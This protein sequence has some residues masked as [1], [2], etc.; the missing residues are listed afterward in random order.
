[1]LA[2]CSRC[3]ASRYCRQSSSPPATCPLP[4]PRTAS[5]RP[6]DSALVLVSSSGG[7]FETLSVLNAAGGVLVCSATIQHLVG[8]N[9]GEAVGGSVPI[10][11]M[12][13]GRIY[14]TFLPV[15]TCTVVHGYMKGNRRWK[16]YGTHRPATTG[17]RVVRI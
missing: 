4:L 10:V 15:P 14:I 17:Q 12:V 2:G 13:F 3:S 6:G 9:P 7:P 1:V 11:R 8:G 5:W 16:T